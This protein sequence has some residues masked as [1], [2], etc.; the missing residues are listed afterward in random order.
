MIID[1]KGRATTIKLLEENTED[2]HSNLGLG[3][4]FSNQDTKSTSMKEKKQ[5]NWIS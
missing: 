2:N 4:V 1:L 3:N 5:I